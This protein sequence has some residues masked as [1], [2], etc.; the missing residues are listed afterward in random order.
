MAS[1][2]SWSE[3][4]N[5]NNDPLEYEDKWG[6]VNQPNYS[7]FA[8]MS[9]FSLNNPIDESLLRGSQFSFELWIKLAIEEGEDFILNIL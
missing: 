4:P 3:N 7:F 1:E 5:Q 6:K 8:P 9:G 2:L